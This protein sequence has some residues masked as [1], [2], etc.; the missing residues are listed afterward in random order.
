MPSQS[1]V[2]LV[3][4]ASSGIGEATARLLAAR[5]HK[6]VLGARR[7]DRIETIAEE[8]RAVGGEATAL[9]LDVTIRERFQ[10]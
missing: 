3:T 1:K 4:G 10:A 9:P 5:G 2:I 8:I 6:L 7:E